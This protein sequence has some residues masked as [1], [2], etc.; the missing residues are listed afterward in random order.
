MKKK[1][2]L[3]PNIKIYKKTQKT[4]ISHFTLPLKGRKKKVLLFEEGP[5]GI[6]PVKDLEH[7][8]LPVE[9]K[10]HLANLIV[11]K[12]AFFNKW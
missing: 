12:H 11:K 3:P 5:L 4:S 6:Y 8:N 9:E 2:T 1:Y 10:I 7:K